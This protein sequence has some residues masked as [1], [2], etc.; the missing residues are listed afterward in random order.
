MVGAYYHLEDATVEEKY[1]FVV[2]R[3]MQKKNKTSDF[4]IFD[5]QGNS[6]VIMSPTDL[7]MQPTL[8][9]RKSWLLKLKYPAFFENVLWVAIF[10]SVGLII[11]GE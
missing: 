1:N 3:M 4:F 8:H 11:T 10:N 5:I 9:F 2:M 7:K 6:R